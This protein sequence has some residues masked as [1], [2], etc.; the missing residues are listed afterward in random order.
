M[1][2]SS[3]R[4]TVAV[5]VVLVIL[6]ASAVGY[7][8][9]R[10]EPQQWQANQ[11]ARNQTREEAAEI[12]ASE[13]V[14]Y[15]TWILAIFSGALAALSGVQ[16]FFLI[17]ADNRAA[18]AADIANKQMLLTGRQADILE[19]QQ[20]LAREQYVSDQRAYIFLHELDLYIVTGLEQSGRAVRNFRVTPR[21]RNSGKTPTKDL[22][23]AFHWQ[24]L[25]GD[26]PPAFPYN[27]PEG[28][29][30]FFVGP[31]AD[32]PQRSMIIDVAQANL[33]YRSQMFPVAGTNPSKLF[34]WG[35]AE[36]KDVF[37]KVCFSE[38]CYLAVFFEEPQGIDIKFVQWGP[39]NRTEDG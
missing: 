29:M 6:G 19:R 11:E 10:F 31:G 20:G 22:T 14:A 28:P 5:T 3:R 9:H 34:I 35:R 18:E 33:A 39:Y 12:L 8:V 30:P 4:L 16:I 21:W 26:L 37:D 32:E 1:L 23:V 25:P 17:R 15:Y 38:C 27:Y 36:Y 7:A 2:K 13:R 24:V